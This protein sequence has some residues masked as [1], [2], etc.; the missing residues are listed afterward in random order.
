MY[1]RTY[2][3]RHDAKFY[4][5]KLQR[6][7]VDALNA[8]CESKRIACMRSSVQHACR[9]RLLSQVADLQCVSSYHDTLRSM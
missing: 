1:V 7:T 6:I 9:I 4:Q 3:R 8:T 2:Y 5:Y